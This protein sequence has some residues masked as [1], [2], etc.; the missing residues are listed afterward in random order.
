MGDLIFVKG[1]VTIHCSL[2]KFVHPHVTKQEALWLQ[3]GFQAQVW[4]EDCSPENQPPASVHDGE[5]LN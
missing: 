3:W 1:T 4:L 2:L 5:A